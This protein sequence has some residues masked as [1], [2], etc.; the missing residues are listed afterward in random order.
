MIPFRYFFFFSPLFL[1]GPEIVDV[2]DDGR[3]DVLIVLF[4]FT[5]LSCESLSAGCFSIWV[6]SVLFSWDVLPLLAPWF[7]FGFLVDADDFHVCKTGGEGAEM[8][9]TDCGGGRCRI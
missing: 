9:R 3:Q 4:F 6:H 5:E 7:G 1:C 2:K 8:D